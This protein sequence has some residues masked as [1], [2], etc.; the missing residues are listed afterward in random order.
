VISGYC[1]APSPDGKAE[2]CQS[3]RTPTARYLNDLYQNKSGA[4][5]PSTARVRADVAYWRPAAVVAV[6]SRDSRLG[7]YLSNVFGPPTLQEGAVLA[8]RPVKQAQAI[9]SQATSTLN[10]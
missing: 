5:P 1:I 2:I 7:R 10:G 8:W 6:T 3:G 4:V 9:H